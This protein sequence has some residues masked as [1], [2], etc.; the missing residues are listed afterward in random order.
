MYGMSRVEQILITISTALQRAMS[1]LSYYTEGTTPDGF[2]ELPKDFTLEQVQQWTEWFNSEMSGQSGERHKIRFVLQDSKYMAT[3][4]EILKDVF[5]EWLA[6]IICYNFSLS[7][8]A[9]VKETN[10]ATAQTAK[11]SAQEEGLEPTKLW[12]KDLM[13]DILARTG[14]DQLEWQWEDEE[15]VDPMMKAK[16]AVSLRGGE[17]GTAK[18]VITLEEQRAMMGLPPAS[19]DQL[20]ELDPPTPEPVA[21]IPGATFGAAPVATAGTKK[22]VTAA[23]KLAFRK[24]KRS[25]GGRSLPRAPTE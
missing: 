17:T 12:F 20:T 2:M 5:D 11:A 19:P 7:P 24:A 22:P 14:D 8:Q 21:P 25:L 9:L 16:V 10:R 4:T 15:I 6:R 13:D 1:Q 23:E 3:K 18:P